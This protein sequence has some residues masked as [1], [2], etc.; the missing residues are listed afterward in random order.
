MIQKAATMGNWSLAASS[1]WTC[2]SITSVQF[3]GKTSNHPG[4]SAS[5]QP[6][7]GA[8]RLLAFPQTK[9]T[10]EREEIFQTVDEIQ[11][12]TMGQLMAT[13]KTGW[14]P[15]VPT[16][17][18]TEVPLSYVQ[19]FLYTVPSSIN[20]SIFPYYIWLDTFW[21]DLIYPYHGYYSAI[22]RI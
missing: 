4:D 6:W 21:R 13:G 20:V 8:L 10:F 5:L 16:L 9:I 7:L 22:K 3:F 11:K 18:G 17:K 1:Q 19:C 12:N 14:G 15:K 2:S